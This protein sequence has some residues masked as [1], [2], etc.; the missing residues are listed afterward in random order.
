MRPLLLMLLLLA[1]RAETCSFVAV[2]GREGARLAELDADASFYYDFLRDHARPPNDDGY[3]LLYYEKALV[4]PTQT[5]Y[6]TG[7]QVWHRHGDGGVLEAAL[8]AL[9]DPA[10]GAVL[11]LGH[12][13]NGSGGAGSHPFTFEW[14]GRTWSFMHNGD[15]SDGSAAGLKE[16]LLSGL[17]QSGWYAP[18]SPVRRSNWKGDPDDVASWI[19]SE[20]LFHYFMA[21]IIAAEGDV[22]VGLRRALR[23]QDYFGFDVRA[24]LVADDPASGPAS[25]V[26]FVLA[27]GRA[28][29]VYKNAAPDD[30]RHELSYRLW[31]SGLAGVLTD[32]AMGAQAVGRYELVTIPAQGGPARHLDVYADPPDDGMP[33]A[34]RRG[35][36]GWRQLSRNGA[37]DSPRNTAD[38]G[39]VAAT[40]PP[41]FALLAAQPNPFNARTTIHLRLTEELDL[42]L[43]IH[44]LRG[45]AVATLYAGRLPAGDHALPWSGQTDAGLPAASGV[46]VCVASDGRTRQ[47]ARVLLL[48]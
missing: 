10:R 15:L 33:A 3:G 7:E 8:A 34:A 29:Y 36:R 47:A 13:R 21:A 41:A 37:V 16:A 5:F 19:D 6:A 1:I 30:V 11:A 44:D 17:R 26:N 24:D 20:L 45:R 46:Y 35:P 38:S 39:E 43:A 32:N 28:L 23:E 22:A 12:A 2:L 40:R 27:D 31:D 9:R 48:K 14:D 18:L 42:S 4:D 25:I